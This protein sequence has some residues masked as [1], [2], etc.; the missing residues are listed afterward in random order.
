ME[1]D[2]AGWWRRTGWQPAW[3]LQLPHLASY[4]GFIQKQSRPSS[5]TGDEPFRLVCLKT[6]LTAR[7]P[8]TN[9]PHAWEHRALAVKEGWGTALPAMC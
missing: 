7:S 6:A 9:G 4:G 2:Q 3:L 5:N 1:E 8:L